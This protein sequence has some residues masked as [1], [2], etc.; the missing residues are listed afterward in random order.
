MLK[1]TSHSRLGSDFCQN[2]QFPFSERGHESRDFSIFAVP[3]LK[4]DQFV[5]DWSL[6]EKA[7]GRRK[8]LWIMCLMQVCTVAFGST[9]RIRTHKN[10]D[11]A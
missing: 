2:G 3:A 8:H 10:P 6:G 4:L 9:Q 5:P 7:W 11:C 1:F